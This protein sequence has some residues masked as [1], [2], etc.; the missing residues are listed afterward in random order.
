MWALS[1]SLGQQKLLHLLERVR[2]WGQSSL[3]STHRYVDLIFQIF[4]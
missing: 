2:T 4:C 3:K 1:S